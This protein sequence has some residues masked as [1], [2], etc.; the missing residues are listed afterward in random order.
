MLKCLQLRVLKME[1]NADFQG[2]FMDFNNKCEEL[3][4]EAMALVDWE[5]TAQLK[6]SDSLSLKPLI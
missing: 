3:I 5:N 2:A 1:A 6:V 4:S